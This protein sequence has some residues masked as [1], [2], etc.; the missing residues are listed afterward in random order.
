MGRLQGEPELTAGMPMQVWFEQLGEGGPTLPQ[1][2]P[3]EA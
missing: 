2:K 3:A 1:W